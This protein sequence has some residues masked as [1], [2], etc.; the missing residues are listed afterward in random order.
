[1]T[2]YYSAAGVTLYC[3]DALAVLRTLPSESVQCCVTSPPYY[4]LRDYKVDGQIGLESTPEAYVASLVAVFEEVWRVLRADGVLWLNLGDSYAS[5]EIGRHDSVQGREIDGKPVTSKAAERQQVHVKSGLKPKD[6]I[7]IPWRVAFALQSAGWYLRAD[8]I[9]HKPNP[10]PESVTDRPTK[11]HEYV[12]LLAKSE[13]YFYDNVAVQEVGSQTSHGG[14]LQKHING[15]TRKVKALQ[16]TDSSTLGGTAAD[17]SV[18]AT[19]NARSVFT[20]ATTPYSGAHFAT[21]PPELARK[22]VLSGSY[23]G[24]VILDP[25]NG[26][27]TTGLVALQEGRHYIGIDLSAAYLDLSI[28]RLRSTIAQPRLVPVVET[29]NSLRQSSLFADGN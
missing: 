22:C 16:N 12:F 28:E 26:A 19:R 11:S 4:N 25:F 1:M 9:W 8:C 29:T 20:I 23:A 7:G 3:G 2:P 15:N 10:M 14:T 27:G 21:M 18:A 5:G 24:S 6:L 13:R 17:Y